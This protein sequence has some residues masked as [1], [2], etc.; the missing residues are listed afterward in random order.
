MNAQLQFCENVEQIILPTTFQSY[1]LPLEQQQQ[2]HEHEQNS[3]FELIKIVPTND[4]MS[5]VVDLINTMQLRKFGAPSNVSFELEARLGRIKSSS[6]MVDGSTHFET[7]VDPIFYEEVASL[8]DEFKDWSYISPVH[9]IAEH[10]YSC[11][12]P[13]VSISNNGECGSSGL[14]EAEVRMV[15]RTDPTLEIGQNQ[16][17]NIIDHIE[18]RRINHVDI[19]TLV[20]YPLGSCGLP[21]DWCDVRFSL[22]EETKINPE[23]LPSC[24]IMVHMRFMARQTYVYKSMSDGTEW[25]Y[26]LTRTWS[27][28]TR[29]EAEQNIKNNVPPVYEIEIELVD[30]GKVNYRAQDLAQSLIMKTTDLFACSLDRLS[31]SSSMSNGNASV[32]WSPCKKIRWA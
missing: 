17:M 11:Y 29:S 28:P 5:S 20:D 22:S 15:L 21:S 12:L 24:A 19:Q 25:H 18:K 8:L 13:T 10:F 26:D 4:T 27:A 1:E 23:H 2:Q 9:M 14:R 7:G 32:Q 3:E 31:S 30:I 6:T 16:D